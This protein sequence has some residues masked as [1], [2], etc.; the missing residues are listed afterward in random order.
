MTHSEKFK[1]AH[2]EL[3]E[4]H[5]V[6]LRGGAIVLFLTGIL[7]QDAWDGT[8]F[9]ESIGRY[10]GAAALSHIFFSSPL[11]A[12]AIHPAIKEKIDSM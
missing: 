10:L 7:L 9:D 5:P 6:A 11:M 3:K 1:A 2:K 4:E 12:I 8:L